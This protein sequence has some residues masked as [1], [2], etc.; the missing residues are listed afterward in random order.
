MVEVEL[1]NFVHS[2]ELGVRV[3]F[4]DMTRKF[5]VM[6][7]SHTA[8]TVGGGHRPLRYPVSDAAIGVPLFRPEIRIVRNS[9]YHS[10]YDFRNR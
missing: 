8:T 1:R 5:W 2:K 10:K 4:F 9:L 6:L 7:E 3:S